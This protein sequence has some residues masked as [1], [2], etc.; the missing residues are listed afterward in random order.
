MTIGQEMWPNLA[1][2]N[3]F[4][5]KPVHTSPESHTCKKAEC[6]VF[7]EKKDKEALPYLT[8]EILLLWDK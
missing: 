7:H 3:G 6:A 2:P 1:P 4:Q 8:A 5:V